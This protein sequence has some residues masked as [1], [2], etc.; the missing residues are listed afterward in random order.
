MKPLFFFGGVYV[1]GRLTLT[2]DPKHAAAEVLFAQ[3][4]LG[5]GHK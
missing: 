3:L 1:R 2:H 4:I 5:H